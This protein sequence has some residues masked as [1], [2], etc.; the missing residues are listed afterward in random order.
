[1]IGPRRVVI[2][3]LGMVSPLSVGVTK[4]WERILNGDSA[5]TCIKNE[6]IVDGADS[7]VASYVDQGLINEILSQKPDH[8]KIPNK[9][10]IS[11]STLFGLI[12]A[13]EAITDA[14]LDTTSYNTE[15]GVAVGQGIID[16]EDV[17]VNG[18]ILNDSGRG[19]KKINPHFITRTL[20]NITAGNI[21]IRYKL[22]GPNH[23]VST[24]CSTGAHAIGD[25]FN[26]IRN[27]YASVMVCGG[28]EASINRITMAGFGRIRALCNK[29]HD[30]PHKA[31]RP[32]DSD[33]CGFVIGEG[34]GILVLEDLAHAL[35]RKVDKIYAEILGYGLSADAHHLT[36]PSPDG[37]GAFRS[38]SMALKNANLEDANL[39]SHVNAH[40][41]STPLGDDIEC[42]AIFRLLGEKHE[43]DLTIMSCKGSLG[44]LLGAAGSVESIFGILA[45]YYAKLPPCANLDKPLDHTMSR[46]LLGGSSRN[47]SMNRRVMLKN[48]F[49]FGGTNASLVLSNY[50]E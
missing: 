26:F 30:E 3:G 2:T 32:F 46:N 42:D 34:A 38:M 8:I 40:A 37:S 48:S 9:K 24:A 25:A 19:Y 1:M 36:A 29:F 11:R 41:T 35:N 33:R 43:R 20:T 7:R 15:C 47:W 10:N 45:C 49:G 16:M 50:L 14:K 22:S 4:S 21:S 31:S 27:G 28:I 5:V 17:L 39:I 18:N 44:H 13:H 12:A 23:S 6:H